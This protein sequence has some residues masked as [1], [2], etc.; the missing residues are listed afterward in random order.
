MHLG[1]FGEMENGMQ[2]IMEDKEMSLNID[3][4]ALLY[5]T[6]RSVF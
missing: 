2:V 6:R 4:K 1:I 3:V 5:L